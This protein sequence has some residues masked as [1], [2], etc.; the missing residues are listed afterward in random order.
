ME[1]KEISKIVVVPTKNGKGYKLFANNKWHYTSKTKLSSMVCG[2]NKGVTFSER[3]TEFA[4]QLVQE[5]VKKTASSNSSYSDIDDTEC[6]FWTEKMDIDW[7]N[8]IQEHSK[9]SA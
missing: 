6:S 4:P 3:I 2:V 1:N 7:Q 5:A 9:G 8:W